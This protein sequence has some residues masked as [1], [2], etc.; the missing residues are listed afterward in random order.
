MNTTLDGWIAHKFSTMLKDNS[1]RGRLNLEL[2]T[3]RG[4]EKVVPVNTT[5]ISQHADHIEELMEHFM[6]NKA[7]QVE[8]MCEMQLC[9]E[10]LAADA[11]QIAQW[12]RSRTG[13]S[14]SSPSISCNLRY[15]LAD[16]INLTQ[17]C[18]R[19]QPYVNSPDKRK[20]SAKRKS[21]PSMQSP[22]RAKYE[23]PITPSIRKKRIVQAVDKPKSFQVY[24]HSTN[25]AIKLC[26][27]PQLKPF[28]ASR[29]VRILENTYSLL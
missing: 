23:S 1:I 17:H 13:S 7:R 18:P 19:T 8:P 20:S 27:G 11:E 5:E 15:P 12:G 21:S 25:S 10:E 22:Q 24:N 29:L 3:S 28:T 4:Y 2:E 16:E 14:H 9:A 26:P 6:M